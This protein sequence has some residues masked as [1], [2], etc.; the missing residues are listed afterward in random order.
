ME[1]KA[2]EIIKLHVQCEESYAVKHDGA[3]YLNVIPIV[4]GSF[5]GKIRGQVINGGADWN[6]RRDNGSAHVFAKY[7][8]RAENGD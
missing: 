1:L 5:D 6:T 7:L 8:L 4:S 3:G 2:E